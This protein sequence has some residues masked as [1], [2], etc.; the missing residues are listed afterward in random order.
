M[1]KQAMI[2]DIT[3]RKSMEKA[4]RESSEKIKLFAYSVSHDLRS[5]AV[6]IYGLTRA[7]SS[8]L[9]GDQLDEKGRS[10]C[11]QILKTAEQIAALAEQI[12][13]YISS[14][15]SPLQIESIKF[16]EITQMIREE[17]SPQ[18]SI[19][20]IRW[21]ESDSLPE[22]RADRL[23]IL[24]VL[25][26]LVDN[27]LKYAGDDLTELARGVDGRRSLSCSFLKERRCDHQCGAL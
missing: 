24:R 7:P 16:K 19:R 26:N 23:C 2:L 22:I 8:G 10:Y 11:S 13:L 9:R 4:L 3:D 6:G 1:S 18:L 21:L 27:A 5:P 20:G 25:R 12:M 17:F 15:E 14:K